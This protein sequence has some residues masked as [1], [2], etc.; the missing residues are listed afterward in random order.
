[1]FYIFGQRWKTKPFGQIELSCLHCGKNTMHTAQ[2]FKG[3]FTFFFIPV[4]PVWG[5]QYQIVCNLCGTKRKAQGEL[6]KQ[7]KVLKAK[8]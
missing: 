7:L 5:K 6:Q 3:K 4:A 2:L 1:M 8:A